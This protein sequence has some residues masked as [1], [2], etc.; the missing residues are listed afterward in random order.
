MGT[1]SGCDYIID[2]TH[3]DVLVTERWGA[4]LVAPIYIDLILTLNHPN[5]NHPNP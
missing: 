5:L 4:T 1:P 3:P 2:K